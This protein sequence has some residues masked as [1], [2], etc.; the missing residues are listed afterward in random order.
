MGNSLSRW[1][2]VQQ[3]MWWYHSK[4]KASHTYQS[5]P[6]QWI[7]NLRPVWLWGGSKGDVAANIY[8]LGNSMILIPGF[9]CAVFYAFREK[10]KQWNQWF[11][12]LCYFFFW[13]PWSISPRIMFF[14]H[15]LP[16]VPFLCMILARY[17]DMGLRSKDIRA[18][19]MAYAVLGTSAAWFL[20][21]YPNMTGIGVPKAFANAVYFGLSSWK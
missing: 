12:L 5:A 10:T 8:N 21:F 9:L 3:Q 1:W 16:A 2:T 15:Y 4:L 19:R 7:F 13:V 20:L 11:V 14:Y 6:W 17:T 18:K